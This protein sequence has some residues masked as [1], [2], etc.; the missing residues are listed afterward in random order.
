ME[1]NPTIIKFNCRICGKYE[2][3]QAVYNLLDEICIDCWL[4]ENGIKREDN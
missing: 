4:K 2:E 1:D 3:I